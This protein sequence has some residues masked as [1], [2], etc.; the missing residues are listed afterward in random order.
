MTK[1][2]KKNEIYDTKA[3]DEEITSINTSNNKCRN[4]NFDNKIFSTIDKTKIDDTITIALTDKTE[5]PGI[6]KFLK[7]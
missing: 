1:S 5:K 7:I 2:H 6:P 4:C 3:N